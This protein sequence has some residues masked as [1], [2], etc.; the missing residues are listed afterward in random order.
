MTRMRHRQNQ[1]R[2]FDLMRGG[3]SM[4]TLMTSFSSRGSAATRTG[5]WVGL[6]HFMGNAR[7]ASSMRRIIPG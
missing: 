6:T 3:A 4:S 5:I 1:A 2:K 7:S